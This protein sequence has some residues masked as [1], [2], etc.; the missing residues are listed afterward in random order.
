MI[1]LVFLD[2]F[3]DDIKCEYG[4]SGIEKYRI[5]IKG[6]LLYYFDL[7]IKSSLLPRVKEFFGRISDNIDKNFLFLRAYLD[8]R[9]AYD[10]VYRSW[11]VEERRDIDFLIFAMNSKDFFDP[12]QYFDCTRMPL[13]RDRINESL[14]IESIYNYDR[15]FSTLRVINTSDF[16]DYRDY[17]GEIFLLIGVRNVPF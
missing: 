11:W 13:K 2:R 3:K 1:S 16:I 7:V 17:S 10:L 4:N 12:S 14:V 8:I 6:I 5:Y 9:D 15:F